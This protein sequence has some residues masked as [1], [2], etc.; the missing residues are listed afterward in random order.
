MNPKPL[1]LLV[2]LLGLSNLLMAQGDWP[3]FRGPLGH[4]KA[5]DSMAYPEIVNP[6]ENL[7]WDIPVNTGLSSP[8]VW[9]DRIFLTAHRADTFETF[10]I[11]YYS[12]TQLWKNEVL[13]DSI[14]RFHPISSA[15]APS[16][17]TNGSVV[18]SYFG[19]YGLQAFN[20][21]GEK[22]WERKLPLQG[23]MYGISVSPVFI[24]GHL[25]FSR[26]NDELSYL[27]V[28]E[29]LTGETVWRTDRPNYKGN[30]STPG[31]CKVNGRT[32]ILVYGVFSMKAYDLETGE[33]MW[34]LPKL[35]DEPAT[36]PL[37]AHGLVY[38]TTYN[39]KTNPEVLGLPSYDSLLQLYDRNNDRQL[40]FEEI[41]E[42]KSILSRYDADGEGDHP[43]PGFFRGLD[44]DRDGQLTRMEWDRIVKWIDSFD[45]KNALLAIKPPLEK[46]GLPSLVW[47]YEYG[48]P[49]CPSPLIIE[50][51]IYMVKNGGIFTCL[52]ALSGEKYY[53]QKLGA[54][55]PYYAS[56]VYADG[57]IYLASTRGVIT[58]L[59]EGKEY[60]ILSQ[61][62]LNQR[63]MA[64]PAL[65]KGTIIIRTDRS[66]QAFKIQMP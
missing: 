40:S 58:I 29:A 5:V 19:S 24:D 2:L 44:R 8:V 25:V 31:F 18:L 11:D 50:D 34:T 60:Q 20:F 55:G 56:P 65:V 4:G 61:N 21:N 64:T 54:G 37:S 47:E 15:V 22:L 42:N 49:E 57:K 46:G 66:L 1:F 32:Q 52:N 36:T 48:V 53:E 43:L 6:E 33:E 63:I 14:E 28:I 35:T 12:G 41:K 45:W 51:R 9:K 39:M 23:N 10:C 7:L 38:V 3:I 27:E 13:V 62:N 59:R 16:I 26:D 17:A 30:W